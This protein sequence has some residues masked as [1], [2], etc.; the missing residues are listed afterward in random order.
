MKKQKK[1]KILA[2]GWKR[3][4]KTHSFIGQ[5]NVNGKNAK[6]S[7]KYFRIHKNHPVLS[8]LLD[9]YINN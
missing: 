7:F 4:R 1:K 2:E 8:K 5:K 9:N 6:K 3:T